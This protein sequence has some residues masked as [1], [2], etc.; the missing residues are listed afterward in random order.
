MKAEN[1][2]LIRASD[3]FTLMEILVAVMLL[4]IS[5]TLIMQQFSGGI[6]NISLSEKYS[7]AVTHARNL[8]EEILAEPVAAE[9]D[10]NGVIDE[11][12]RWQ[13][14]MRFL[15]PQDGSNN[16][17]VKQLYVKVRVEWDFLGMTRDFEL[18]TVRTVIN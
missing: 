10:Q 15:K 14:T 6:R 16:S 18:E 7:A 13:R 2:D 5:L 3:G 12:F 17:L 4:S 11:E 9:G 8:M 1:I